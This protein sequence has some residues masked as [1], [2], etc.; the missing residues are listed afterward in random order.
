MEELLSALGEYRQSLEAARQ[1]SLRRLRQQITAANL[2]GRRITSRP[3]GCPPP[4][5][6]EQQGVMNVLEV[7]SVAEGSYPGLIVLKVTREDPKGGGSEEPAYVDVEH[8]EVYLIVE[9]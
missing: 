5:K 6:K 4:E 7:V 2:A 8:D 9:G 1:K 3:I